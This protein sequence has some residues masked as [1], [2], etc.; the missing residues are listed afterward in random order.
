MSHFLRFYT[1]FYRYWA[2]IRTKLELFSRDNI[3]IVLEKRISL[4]KFCC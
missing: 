3:K 1:P 2:N 4:N